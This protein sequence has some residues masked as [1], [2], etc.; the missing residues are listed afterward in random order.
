MVF[1]LVMF[2]LRTS[3]KTYR[4]FFGKLEMGDSIAVNTVGCVLL[5]SECLGLMSIHDASKQ[6]SDAGSARG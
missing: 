5:K 1:P 6:A 4:I 3:Y 2:V